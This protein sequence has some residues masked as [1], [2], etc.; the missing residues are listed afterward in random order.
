M[1]C[2]LC[3]PVIPFD[4]RAGGKV[5]TF[6]TSGLLCAIDGYPAGGC[7]DRTGQGGYH[8]WSYW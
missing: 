1:Y 4:A 6:G 2:T 7:G 8:Y 3:G 5:L